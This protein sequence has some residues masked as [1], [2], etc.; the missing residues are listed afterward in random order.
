MN[1][2]H[3]DSVATQVPVNLD[4]VKSMHLGMKGN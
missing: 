4:D 3:S 2:N 1:T